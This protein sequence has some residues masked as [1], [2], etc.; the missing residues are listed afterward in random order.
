MHHGNWGTKLLKPIKTKTNLYS[1]AT[2]PFDSCIVFSVK[3]LQK[4]DGSESKQDGAETGSI[5]SNALPVC[6]VTCTR[7]IS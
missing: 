5:E 1:A 7:P 6:L 4:E 3:D 2:M